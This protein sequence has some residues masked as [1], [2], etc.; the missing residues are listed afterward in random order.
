[1]G[2]LDDLQDNMVDMRTR[3]EK[4]KRKEQ[5]G[6]LDDEE[7]NELRQLRYGFFDDM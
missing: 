6:M 7:R 1:M 5:A 4:L 2:L 3:F